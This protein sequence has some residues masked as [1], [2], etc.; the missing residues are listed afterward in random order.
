M[1]VLEAG[2]ITAYASLFVCCEYVSYNAV[3]NF[4]SSVKLPAAQ[5]VIYPVDSAIDSRERIASY[6]EQKIRHTII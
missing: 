2:T 1:K 3:D 6:K 5:N 4:C